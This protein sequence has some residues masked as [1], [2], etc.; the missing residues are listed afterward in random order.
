MLLASTSASF[1]VFSSS[2]LTRRNFSVIMVV[3]LFFLINLGI[4][5]NVLVVIRSFLKSK[6]LVNSHEVVI[7]FFV[8]NCRWLF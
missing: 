4:V 7:V 2:R 5:L 6:L 8:N 1:L 3:C